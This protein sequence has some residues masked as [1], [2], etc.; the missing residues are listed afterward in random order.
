MRK[1]QHK[2]LRFS[3]TEQNPRELS[4]QK[5]WEIENKESIK[6][7]GS[8]EV[9]LLQFLFTQEGG[10]FFFGWRKR[11]K[12]I[13]NRDRMIVATVIQWLGSNVGFCFLERMLKSAGYELKRADIKGE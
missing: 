10:S 3:R 4:F 1:V 8:N 7:N 2:G 11:V 5:S 9:D 13:T 6:Y 12:T